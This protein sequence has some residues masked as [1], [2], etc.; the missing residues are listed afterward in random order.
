MAMSAVSFEFQPA[1]TPPAPS[2][3]DV[4][5]FVGFVA[6]RVGSGALRVVPPAGVDAPSD[7]PLFAGLSEAGWAERPYRADAEGRSPLY[8]RASGLSG[9]P[10]PPPWTRSDDALE[11]LL[12]VPVP[13]ESWEAFDRLFA[14]DT[15]PLSASSPTDDARLRAATYLGAAVRSFFAQG[16][17]RCYVIRV[18]DPWPLDAAPAVREAGLDRLLP[19]FGFSPRAV[20][21]DRTTWRGLG[22][23]FGLPDVSFVCLPDL[24]DAV[25]SQLAP[26]KPALA[27]PA[28]PEGFV[29]C[30]VAPAEAEPLDRIVRGLPAPRCTRDGY[31]RWASVLAAIARLL[32]EPRNGLRE[33]QLVASVPLPAHD[34]PAGD[35]LR[36]LSDNGWLA[37]SSDAGNEAPAAFASAFVQLAWPWLETLGSAALPEGLEGADAALV[38]VLARSALTRASYRCAAGQA[39]NGVYG[40]YP[41]LPGAD[42]S[43]S[44]SRETLIQRVSL[45][46]PTPSGMQVL[47]D[48]TTY[49][50]DAYRQG[51]VN[52]LV[53]ALVR[54]TRE[55][56]EDVA[57]APSGPELWRRVRSS[58]EALLTRLWRDG[59][60][61]GR[62]SREAFEVRCDRSTMT[63]RDLDDGRVLVDVRF[64]AAHAIETIRVVLALSEGAVSVVGAA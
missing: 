63:Q 34:V 62:T 19:G 24:A 21:T 45:L 30:S 25:A 7:Y 16:G 44:P 23:L 52:R 64:E 37:G 38:G 1:A 26:L 57:F 49:A 11:S 4:A 18:G 27:A 5:C 48:V 50:G 28:P 54:A 47:S 6:R 12:D 42:R 15:R 32:R 59:A 3:A 51:N 33:V 55:L 31:E 36:W 35:L 29:E 39:L 2:R 9:A 53:S 13:V 56:G 58:L 60:L 46:G 14:W 40:I 22:H 43:R 8:G 61:R 20:R 41:S 17:R 10:T